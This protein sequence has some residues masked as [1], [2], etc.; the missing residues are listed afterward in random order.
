MRMRR[1]LVA[2]FLAGCLLASAAHAFA[3][4][5]A[6]G[7]LEVGAQVCGSDR[8]AFE[9]DDEFRARLTREANTPAW[10]YAA[11]RKMFEG[12]NTMSFTPQTESGQRVLIASGII[13]DGAAMRLRDA[14]R[15]Y[16]PIAEV[17]FN[18]PGGSSYVGTEMGELLRSEM[19][20]T[21]VKQ[22][23]AC[24]SACST[25]FIGGVIRNVEPGAG[26]GVHMFSSQLTD[27]AID[28]M[29]NSM[30]DRNSVQSAYNR[31]QQK[32]AEGA[33]GRAEYVMRMGV[34]AKWLGIWSR[35]NPGC[36]TYLSQKELRD[37]FVD[38]SD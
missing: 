1:C 10:V 21:R 26:Y 2:G 16:A 11:E 19:I 17:W 18:S 22:G 8:L 29:R 5:G 4:T 9:S 27:N 14:L 37:L 15:S 23:D 34:S 30:A 12:G 25:A 32:G 35:T 28:M 24:A 7:Q 31:F 38:N 6:S 33:A 3:Q 13:D 36:M 20:A